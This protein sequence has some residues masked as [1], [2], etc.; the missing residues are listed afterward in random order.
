MYLES[1]IF[2]RVASL[3]IILS[4]GRTTK[5]L[6][7][8][9]GCVGWSAPLIFECNYVR[10]SLDTAHKYDNCHYNN[11]IVFQCFHTLAR[12][13]YGW[14]AQRALSMIASI[15]WKWEVSAKKNEPKTRKKG[16][17]GKH[18]RP[19]KWSGARR[20]AGPATT[21]LDMQSQGGGGV[22]WYFHTYIGSGYFLE[23]K[24]LNFNIFWVSRK[25]NIFWGM[26]ILWIFFG[27]YHK[28]GLVWGS[29]LCILGSF[30][31]CT[32]LGYFFGL[33]KFQIFFWGAWNFWYFL[34]VNARC[35]V[36]AYIYGKNLSTP[37]PT[38]P[39]PPW[40]CNMTTFRKK[41]LPVWPDSTGHVCVR[42]EYAL[43]WCSTLHSLEFDMHYDYMY[44][45]K[46]HVLTF[47][48]PPQGLRVCV[49]TEYA[50]SWCS[51]L[52]SL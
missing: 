24:I 9:R 44:F 19:K 13:V 4:R 29:F 36:R 15:N 47:L 43:A 39:P 37:P 52:H 8:L 45:Q 38:P 17:G 32:E 10:F 49:R 35:W 11:C 5:A 33:L 1:W 22:L 20:P 12:S 31:R 40:V 7:R 26:K 3:S 41:V 46:R 18:T 23:F 25:R 21:A 27:G 28:I 2:L 34:G 16:Y 50:L 14:H 48:T 6:I 42:T 51:R 30:L